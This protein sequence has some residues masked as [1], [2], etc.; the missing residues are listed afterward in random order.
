MC[1][2]WGWLSRACEGGGLTGS[3]RLGQ[4][5]VVSLTAQWGVWEE[6]GGGGEGGGLSLVPTPFLPWKG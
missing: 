1:P 6:E 4:Q 3:G 5:A 2:L